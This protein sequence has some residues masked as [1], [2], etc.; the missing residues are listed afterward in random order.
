MSLIFYCFYTKNVLQPNILVF[1][2]FNTIQVKGRTGKVGDRTI[3]VRDKS[4]SGEKSPT[5][6]IFKTDQKRRITHKV[7]HEK[8][9]ETP[10]PSSGKKSGGG[11]W[12]GGSKKKSSG[13]SS[14]SGKSKS[15]GSKSSGGGGGWWRRKRSI[16]VH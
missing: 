7:R 6:E 12:G 11:W 14:S 9:K 16:H 5:V 3:T 8:P 2:V 13:S 4:T 1:K 10:K 15:S